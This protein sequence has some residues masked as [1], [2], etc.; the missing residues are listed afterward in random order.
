MALLASD[1]IY[2]S[3]ESS[4]LLDVPGPRLSCV[5]DQTMQNDFPL[6]F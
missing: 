2:L 4:A 3:L 6:L 1:I 5:P